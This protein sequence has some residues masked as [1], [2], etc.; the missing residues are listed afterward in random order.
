MSIKAIIIDDEYRARMALRNLCDQFIDG[1]EIVAD[2]EDVASGLVAIREC[3]PDLVFLDIKMPVKDGFAL[4]E[5]NVLPD[6]DIIFTTAHQEYAIR[7]MRLQAQDYLLKP[8]GISDLEGA[9]QRLVKRRRAKQS[10]NPPVIAPSKPG[11]DP[12]VVALP[13]EDGMLLTQLS[14]ILQCE[15]VGS[16]TVFH[17]KNGRQVIVTRNLKKFQ[18]QFL[19][20]GFYRVHHRHLVNISHIAEVNSK[21][22]FLLL[23]NGD[24]INISQ[25]KKTG[26][27]KA[28]R[29]LG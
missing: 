4:L 20:K 13:T 24:M 8:I 9:I 6:L 17:L 14:D 25:R 16:Y 3:Q 18:E 1:V 22:N 5:E 2:A 21:S 23:K 28:L 7:A 12:Q 10:G 29:D 26:F 19:D 15:G 27:L 11:A